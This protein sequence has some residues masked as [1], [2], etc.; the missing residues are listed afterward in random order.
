MITI[1]D[2]TLNSSRISRADSDLVASFYQELLSLGVD[3]IMLTP[4]IHALLK[5]NYELSKAVIKQEMG[6]ILISASG[7]LF[8][9]DYVS[10]YQSLLLLP[11]ELSFCTKNAGYAGTALTVEWIAAGGS[12]IVCS[13]M[14]EGGYAPLEEV[15]LALHGCG[16]PL[17]PLDFTRLKALGFLYEKLTGNTIPPHKPILGDRIFEVESGIHIDGILKN[18]RNYE[19]F[20]PEL[21]GAKR[22]FSLGKFS[23]MN[24]V[25]QKLQELKLAY[26]D[27]ETE[28]LLCLIREK[29]MRDQRN[30]S[31]IELYLLLKEQREESSLEV[32]G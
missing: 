9:Q 31:D 24:A 13:V 27:Q 25:R 26:S 15:L 4:E 30:V 11:C 28:A 7:K 2:A 32:T 12:S 1:T 10:V 16:A 21:V 22:L 6:E 19:P 23:G 14:G 8:L 18:H 20:P 5:G 17:K 3:R 29:A